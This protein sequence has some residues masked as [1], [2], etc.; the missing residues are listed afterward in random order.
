MLPEAVVASLGLPATPTDEVRVYAPLGIGSHVDH[1]LV[2]NAAASLADAGWEVWLYEDI[3]YALR[4]GALERR[5]EAEAEL[6]ARL[7]A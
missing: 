4:D 5:A 2:F 6:G 3:P 1:Q 7:P